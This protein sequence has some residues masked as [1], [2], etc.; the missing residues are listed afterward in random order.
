[1]PEAPD[2][3]QVPPPPPAEALVGL[4]TDAWAVLLPTVRAA[5]NDLDGAD[6]TPAVRRL[7]AAPTGR[8]AG[9]RVRREVCA[10]FAAGGPA[11][12]AFYRRLIADDD[13]RLL[14]EAMRSETAT[15][16]AT[17]TAAPPPRQPVPAPSADLE[18]LRQRLREAREERDVLRRRLD[19]AESR[20][21]RAEEAAELAEAEIR[22]LRGDLAAERARLADAE[23][24]RARVVARERR[25]A[26]SGQ[27]KLREELAA[28]RRADEERRIAER[29]AE[30]R[31]RAAEAEAA[32][33]RRE[34]RRERERRSRPPRLVPGRPSR[35]PDGVMP[36]SP[37]GVEMLMHDGRLVLVDGYNLTRR[38]RDH[39]DLET[40]RGWLVQLLAAAALQRRIRPVAVFDG[41]RAS[42][43]RPAI[44]SREVEVRFTPEGITADDEIVLAVE[45]TDEPVVVVTDDRELQARVRVSGADVV[46]TTEFLGALG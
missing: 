3:E 42:V 37:A 28:M 6:A 11:W 44:A 25:R 17:A 26:E 32:Q 8:L 20:A 13:A 34:R 39:L 27:A 12:S 40:Q 10:L 29:R 14:A 41:E 7:R 46:G 21:K 24:E 35:F 38:H 33:D 1:M 15:A 18:R 5:L 4:P 16:T 30:E 43:A 31:R 22:E 2:A 9:G 19:G 45:A 36:G 23:A